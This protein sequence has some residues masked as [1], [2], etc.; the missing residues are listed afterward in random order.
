MQPA[1]GSRPA[2]EDLMESADFQWRLWW[3]TSP[4]PERV[5]PLSSSTMK[6]RLIF[7]SL[8]MLCMSCVPRLASTFTLC[9]HTVFCLLEK[10]FELSLRLFQTAFSEFSGTQVETDFVEVPSQMLENWVW[11]KEPL[12]RMSRHYKDGTPIPDSLL[13]KLISS[14]VANT[15]QTKQ[16]MSTMGRN[17]EW[18]RMCWLLLLQGWWT[19]A[20]SSSVK[21]TSHCTQAL[22]QIQRRCLHSTVRTSWVFLLH[23]VSLCFLQL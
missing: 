15:G 2:A 7:T 12:R 8:V 13:D 9:F 23:Q 5:G 4:S 10:Q 6:W 16:F 3:Q 18:M 21:W 11:E 1:L 22:V 14:R 17:Q 19:C 20:R